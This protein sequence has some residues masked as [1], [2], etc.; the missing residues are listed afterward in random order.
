MVQA[1]LHWVRFARTD[2]HR[3]LSSRAFSPV[4]QAPALLLDP[5][6]P[7]PLQRRGLVHARAARALGRAGWIVGCS[8]EGFLAPKREAS[9]DDV[10]TPLELPTRRFQAELGT[11]RVAEVIDLSVNGV[12]ATLMPHDL[13]TL[14]VTAGCRRQRSGCLAGRRSPRGPADRTGS[15]S[16]THNRPTPD[17][18]RSRPGGRPG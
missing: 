16:G 3:Y 2:H 9:L 10:L 1:R 17:R 7:G 12:R 11:C 14:V 6:L 18:C 8:R 13:R 5:L 15:P 4:S